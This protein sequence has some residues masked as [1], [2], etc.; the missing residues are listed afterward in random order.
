MIEE[1]SKKCGTEKKKHNNSNNQN[2][3]SRA[4]NG[5]DV[6]H[7]IKTIANRTGCCLSCFIHILICTQT[8]TYERCMVEVRH[9]VG[10]QTT[11]QRL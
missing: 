6:E 2:K 1:E 8:H 10:N 4:E 9:S 11:S 5:K 3:H 7:A